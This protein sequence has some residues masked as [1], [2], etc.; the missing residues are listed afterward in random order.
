MI[1]KKLVTAN[2]AQR[3]VQRV[4]ELCEEYQMALVAENGGTFDLGIVSTSMPGAGEPHG[5]R[6]G[7][8]R[9]ISPWF[10]ELDRGDGI[11]RRIR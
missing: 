9:H 7:K 11:F 10:A 2:D 8:L 5:A 3:F 1:D 4:R 6:I